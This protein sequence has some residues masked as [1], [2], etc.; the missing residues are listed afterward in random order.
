[1]PKT[2]K[3][4]SDYYYSKYGNIYRDILEQL[5]CSVLC[6]L[7]VCICSSVLTGGPDPWFESGRP[8][9]DSDDYFVMGGDNWDVEIL[10]SLLFQA[11]LLLLLWV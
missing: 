3:I 11:L 7:P 1:M 4:I 6:L 2:I 9:G 8:H 10:Y 5:R